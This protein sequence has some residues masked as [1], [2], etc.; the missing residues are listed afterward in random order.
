VKKE[1]FREI[2]G[3][4]FKRDIFSVRNLSLM[5]AFHHIDES[6]VNR[7]LRNLIKEGLLKREKGYDLRPVIAPNSSLCPRL[8]GD[9]LYFTQ[10]FYATCYGNTFGAR[11]GLIK[12]I[13]C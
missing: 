12:T 9:R 8:N 2:A 10:S 11:K 7:I 3:N 13:A 5:L 6:L 1:E 4:V